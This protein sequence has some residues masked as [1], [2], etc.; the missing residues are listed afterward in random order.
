MSTCCAIPLEAEYSQLSESDWHNLDVILK[1]LSFFDVATTKLQAVNFTVADFYHAW[2]ELKIELEPL[3]GMELVDNILEQ[4]EI[5]SAE[6]LRNEV[7]YSCVFMDPRY[8]ILLTEGLT[9]SLSIV[10]VLLM[11]M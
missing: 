11:F 2:H 8:R 3:A 5:R 1:I 10:Y 9:S 7:V 6:L 4:M